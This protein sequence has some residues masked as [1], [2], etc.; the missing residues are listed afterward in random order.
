MIQHLGEFAAEQDRDCTDAWNDLW[1]N[2]GDAMPLARSGNLKRFGEHFGAIE[3]RRLQVTVDDA[4]AAGMVVVPQ[5]CCGVFSYWVA[6]NN[7]WVQCGGLLTN[8]NLWS[9]DVAREIARQ[10]MALP[11]SLVCLDWMLETEEWNQV[12]KALLTRGCRVERHLQLEAGVILTDGDWDVFWAQR[13]KGFRKKIKSRLRQLSAIGKIEFER[14]ATFQNVSDL[15]GCIDM[16]LD[17]EHM[18]WKGEQLS[19]LNSHPAIRDFYVKTLQGLAEQ[20]MLE[21]QFLKLDDR[22]I[23]FDIGFRSHGT[24]Y[25]YKI[26]FDPEFSKFSPGQIITYF[27]LQ[28]GFRSD[29]IQRVDTVGAL[30]EATSKWCDET[31]RRYRYVIATKMG[32]KGALAVWERVKPTLKRLL[33]R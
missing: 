9:P 27:Q 1:D 3:L 5:K 14:Q 6:P 23:A 26:G 4:I 33:K 32:S 28:H 12:C 22:S 29:E 24:Y 18:G 16:A 30:S 21:I 2:S 17:L 10:M 15:A 8:K 25:S 31:I 11:G 7:P 20:G 19:S 13:S